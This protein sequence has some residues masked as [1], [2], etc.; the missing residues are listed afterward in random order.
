MS[1]LPKWYFTFCVM[2]IATVFPRIVPAG[3]INF[4]VPT[5]AGTIWGRALFEGGHYSE[6]GI[7][8]LRST[9]THWNYAMECELQVDIP[10]L[11]WG[12]HVHKEIWTP[13]L[14]EELVVGGGVV[15][16]LSGVCHIVPHAFDGLGAG[17]IRG[18]LLLISEYQKGGTI[19]GRALF[20]VRVLFEEIWYIHNVVT[21]DS[22]TYTTSRI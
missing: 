4:R 13:V 15:G 20:A 14:E 18:R 3:T 21:I 22:A 2:I 7:I 19:R 5:H 11:V 8:T 16:S 10:S 9:R 6:E 12:H 17:T 1:Y